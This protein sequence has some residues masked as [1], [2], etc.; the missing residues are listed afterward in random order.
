MSFQQLHNALFSD[1][2]LRRRL[3]GFLAGQKLWNSDT[4]DVSVVAGIVYLSGSI[5]DQPALD[6]LEQAVRRVAGVLG[7][8]TSALRV[9]AASKA[10][11]PHRRLVSERYFVSLPGK[12]GEARA[13]GTRASHSLSER[14][15]KSRLSPRLSGGS[16]APAAVLPEA[17][18]SGAWPIATP[19]EM[20]R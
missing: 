14:L 12:A 13:I 1:A 16:A 20:V 11:N 8:D 19:F 5:A 17:A 18:S 10:R 3:I 2:Q 15:R 7:A 6:R 9:A 4:L